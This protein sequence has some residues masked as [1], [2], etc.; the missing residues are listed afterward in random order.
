MVVLGR[1]SEFLEHSRKYS[2]SIF[3]GAAIINMLPSFLRPVL[4]PIVALIGRRHYA[5]CERICLP[6]VE[7]RLRQNERASREPGFDWKPPVRHV[8]NSAGKSD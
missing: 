1:N 7:E 2:M 6:V 4:G 8:P 3:S 5:I